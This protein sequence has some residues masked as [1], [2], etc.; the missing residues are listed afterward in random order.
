MKG[1]T[2][3]ITVS[4]TPSQSSEK[5][6]HLDELGK[7][8]FGGS[9]VSSST[10]LPP[11][12]AAD[13]KNTHSG[14]DLIPDLLKDGLQIT[15][16]NPSES[17]DVEDVV[18][19]ITASHCE[20][21]DSIATAYRYRENQLKA[22]A[23][24]VITDRSFALEKYPSSEQLERLGE[25][26]GERIFDTLSSLEPDCSQLLVD[27]AIS[28]AT[29]LDAF[30]DFVRGNKGK[31]A[32]CWKARAAYSEKLG[33]ATVYRALT[34][35]KDVAEKVAKNGFEP[36]LF[37]NVKSNQNFVPEKLPTSFQAHTHVQAQSGASSYRDFYN[38]LR[39]ELPKGNKPSTYSKK[40]AENLLRLAKEFDEELKRKP[41]P[42]DKNTLIIQKSFK[43]S[44]KSLETA[45]EKESDKFGHPKHKTFALGKCSSMFRNLRSMDQTLIESK[46]AANDPFQ[47]VSF[48]KGLAS[49]VAN[50]PGMT[51]KQSGNVYLYEM[52]VPDLDLINP[53]DY[54]PK[55]RCPTSYELTDKEGKK[56]SVPAEQAEKIIFGSLH[57]SSIKSY[58]EITDGPKM[59]MKYDNV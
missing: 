16:M 21:H 2:A 42:T 23:K 11:A 34:V 37:R 13:V 18:K 14:P 29:H 47:S 46:F 4:S 38:S 17:M 53:E 5:P 51:G 30:A 22:L 20:V 15:T 43:E 44:L 24:N 59:V 12:T 36:T 32:D 7:A 26:P 39:I 33:S 9:F 50:D 27:P 45:L 10:K 56:T 8:A 54:M 41:S 58:G 3:S 1:I 57:P 49:S 52:I 25:N 28:S 6:D 48:S 19:L 35:P 55:G 40:A 31:F